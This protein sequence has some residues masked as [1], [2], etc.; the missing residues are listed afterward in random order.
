MALLLILLDVIAELR[1]HKRLISGETAFF[2]VLCPEKYSMQI[3]LESGLHFD[4]SGFAFES[5][6]SNLPK[7]RT[8]SLGSSDHERFCSLAVF[9]T[10]LAVVLD[11]LQLRAMLV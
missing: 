1:I 3:Y 7:T 11:A 5:G 10:L 8:V 4:V 9:S 2:K 6:K